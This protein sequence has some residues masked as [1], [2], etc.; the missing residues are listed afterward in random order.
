MK[1]ENIK[2]SWFCLAN[3][4][5][6]A[7]TASSSKLYLQS[8]LSDLL[9]PGLCSFSKVNCF[10]PVWKSAATAA[11]LQNVNVRLALFFRMHYS[12]EIEWL[13]FTLFAFPFP[14][15]RTLKK[16]RLA[17]IHHNSRQFFKVLHLLCKSFETCFSAQFRSCDRPKFS[18]SEWA[19]FNVV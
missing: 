18:T 11:L 14:L 2:K 17:I 5:I 10:L 15:F 7:Y 12:I 3:H 13:L 6:I 9:L 16:F 1:I 19:G 8:S 4:K